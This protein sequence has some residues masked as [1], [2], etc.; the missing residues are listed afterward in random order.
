MSNLDQL[1][2]VLSVPSELIL[3]ND[4]SEDETLM[5]LIEW[6]DT[7][8][9]D[10]GNIVD[11]YIYSSKSQQFET[12]CDSFGILKSNC[13]YVLEIQADMFIEESGFDTRL[14]KA[15][16]S[17][18]DLIALS[19]R[20]CH[21]LSEVYSSF[22]SS[23]GAATFDD[24][25]ISSFIINR[26]RVFSKL[27]LKAMNLHPKLNHSFP[28][29]PM[30]LSQ[31][32][33]VFPALDS[34]Q[35]T[36]CAGKLGQL[37]NSNLSTPRELKNRIWISETVMR[38]PLLIDKVKFLDLGGFDYKSFFL[39]YD[40]HDLFLRAYLAGFSCGYVP[41]NFRSPLETGSSRAPRSWKTELSLTIKVIQ[42]RLN[43]KKS[44]M[45]NEYH[46]LVPRGSSIRYF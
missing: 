32:E 15:L 28:I 17:S 44:A 37:V 24:L 46:K 34:F 36:G 21:T 2:S 30:T 39:G 22:K 6:Q 12:R 3:L 11:I 13:R 18:E 38:G 35:A 27:F 7:Q 20:G 23:M 29:L 4:S 5:K 14:L 8:N 25:S 16:K 33:L 31:T 26:L 45:N 19:G 41:V 1:I 9:G 40:E 43:R 42:I 10:S